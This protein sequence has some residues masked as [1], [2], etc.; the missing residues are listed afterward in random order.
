[1]VLQEGTRFT[2]R[3]LINQIAKAQVTLVE[4]EDGHSD[5]MQNM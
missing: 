4:Y 1:M 3:G 2:V 5:S